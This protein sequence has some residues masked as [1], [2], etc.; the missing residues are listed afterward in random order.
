[1]DHRIRFPHAPWGALRA[2]LRR[3]DGMALRMA[4][5]LFAAGMLLLMFARL[6][7]LG[8]VWMHLKHLD[9]GLALLCGMVFL[10]AY[11]I[12]ALRWR[13][14]LTASGH[15][16]GVVRVVMIYQVALF[17]NWLLPV[18][19]GELAKSLLLRRLDSIPISES[20]STVAMDKSMDLLPAAALL[21]L[22][23]FMPFQLSQPLW[24][25]LLLALL[26]L[27]CGVL[28]LLLAALH[29]QT[30]LLLLSWGVARLPRALRGMEP[31]LLR[32]MDMSLALVVRPQLLLRAGLLTGVAVCLDALFCLLAFAAVGTQVSFPVVLFG[33]TFFNLAFILPTPPGQIGSNELIG[34]LIFNG[35]LGVSSTEVAA[36]FV[37]SHPW[38]AILMA[39]VGALCL[40]AMGQ[41]MR[42]ALA[43]THAQGRPLAPPLTEKGQKAPDFSGG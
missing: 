14:F 26:A 41:S 39:V 29:R 37:F 30:A 24:T 31:F 21:L 23:P 40:S 34:L 22:L 16:T 33:Y 43:L 13:C 12:R 15:D 6:V 27:A 7:N 4:V 28:F 20:L 32:F 19:G 25:L 8:T 17:V 18:R 3:G 9:I 10:S 11:V 5:G 42:S 35:V 1:M 2:R 38:T 36:M